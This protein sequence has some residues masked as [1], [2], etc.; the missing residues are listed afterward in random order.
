[1]QKQ[2]IEEKRWFCAELSRTEYTEAWSMQANLVTARKKRIIDRDIVLLLEHPSVFTIGRRCG[3][4]DLLVSEDFL[5]KQGIQVVKVERGGRITFHGPGQ[6]IMYPIIDLHLA[7][8]G[9]A[10]YI[11]NLEEVMIRA[12]SDFGIRAER[13]PANR[14]VWVRNKKL[15]SVGIAIRRGISFHGY[16]LNVNTC[17]KPFEWIN[18]C[19]LKDVGMTSVEQELSRKVS[20]HK[21][22]KNIK[23]HT[24]SVFGIGLEVLKLKELNRILK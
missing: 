1:M 17:L 10:E 19:G 9:V 21:V 14:G 20:M 6:L 12:A 8:L 23:R 15:G 4:N 13:N 2:D 18:P 24:E 7:R 3:F 22:K 16:A 5:K 11:G